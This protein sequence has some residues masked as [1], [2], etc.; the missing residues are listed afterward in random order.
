M[1][2]Y[3]TNLTSTLFPFICL[4]LWVQ[5]KELPSQLLKLN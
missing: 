5:L 1:K 4:S 2:F 3:K